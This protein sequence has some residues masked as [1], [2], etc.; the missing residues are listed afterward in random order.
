MYYRFESAHQLAINS[1]EF[2]KEERINIAMGYFN[3]LK[4]AFAS[5]THLEV[6]T[7]MNEELQLE[8]QKIETKS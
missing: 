3:S 5:S 7:K 6:A 4:K 2:K 8:I 1:V